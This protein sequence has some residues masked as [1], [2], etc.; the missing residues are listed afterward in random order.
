MP[1]YQC[2]SSGLVKRYV[3]E[4]GSAWVRAIVDPASAN[5]VSIA[6]I[7]ETRHE[8]LYP[9]PIAVCTSTSSGI[10]PANALR[11]ALRPSPRPLP[12]GEGHS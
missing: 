2:D 9:N 12:E 3:D 4:I 8:L 6:D 5:I 1:F 10:G 7:A 11:G